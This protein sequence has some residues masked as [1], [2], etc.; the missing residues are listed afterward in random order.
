VQVLTLGMR[1]PATA[2]IAQRPFCSSAFLNLR[3]VG[4]RAVERG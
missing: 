2:D 3:A 4:F 1:M